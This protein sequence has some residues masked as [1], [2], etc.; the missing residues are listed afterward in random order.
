MVI[1]NSAPSSS[2]HGHRCHRQRWKRRWRRLGGASRQ[3]KPIC[4]SAGGQRLCLRL[5]DTVAPYAISFR[6]G[7]CRRLSET[8]G[9]VRSAFCRHVRGLAVNVSTFSLQTK[10]PQPKT[11]VLSQHIEA[12]WTPVP[13]FHYL[14]TY[15]WSPV[16]AVRAV[17]VLCP[18]SV[19]AVRAIRAIRAIRAN[20]C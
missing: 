12:K 2:S 16:H 4:Q 20:P 9:R 10:V 11:I 3:C 6:P 5:T 19:R 15:L 18:C 13:L 1:G 7:A 17:S 8:E 14:R